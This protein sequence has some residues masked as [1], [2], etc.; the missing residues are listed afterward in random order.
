MDIPEFYHIVFSCVGITGSKDKHLARFIIQCIWEFIQVQC[1]T[2]I[3]LL[4]LWK[5][6]EGTVIEHGE[7]VI[8]FVYSVNLQV[9][10]LFKERILTFCLLD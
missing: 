10:L 7:L 6:R 8:Q 4:L 3:F 9:S 2:F 1:V 5:L